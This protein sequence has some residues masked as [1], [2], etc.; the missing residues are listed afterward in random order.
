[1]IY[2]KW[3][4]YTCIY[5]L[6]SVGCTSLERRGRKERFF[7]IRAHKEGCGH[8]ATIFTIGGHNEGFFVIRVIRLSVL[9][10]NDSLPTGPAVVQWDTAEVSLC[11]GPKLIPWE[12]NFF[13]HLWGSNVLVLIT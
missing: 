1:M 6:R 3:C 12:S 4:I 5:Y 9:T 7:I 2:G 10:R 13:Y 8:K 11:P